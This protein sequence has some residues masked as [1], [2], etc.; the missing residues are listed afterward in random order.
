MRF[1]KTTEYAIRAMVF[2]TRHRDETYSVNR[3]H[4]TLDIP[5]K[6]L[7]RLMGNLATAGLVIVTQGKQG[8]F[9]INLSRFPIYL[10]DII[11]VVEGLE[12]YN[13][14]VLGF[15]ECSDTNP[16]SLHQQWS[17]QLENLREM[18]YKVQLEDLVHENM[19]KF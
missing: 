2:L 11:E 3:L 7:G 10:A 18:I 17:K 14:C 16:C 13:R 8:G 1:S 9:R 19:I 4:Q 5:Y 15:S 6:Y 12:S